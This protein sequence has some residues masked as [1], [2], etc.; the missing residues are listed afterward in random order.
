MAYQCKRC[1]DEGFDFGPKAAQVA[2]SCDAGKRWADQHSPKRAV[3]IQ[4]LANEAQA[5]KDALL[6]PQYKPRS[7]KAG[8][9]AA[10]EVR[11]FWFD[12]T[13]NWKSRDA[14]E[15]TDAR[16]WVRSK[17]G[18]YGVI[19]AQGRPGEALPHIMFDV[20][21]ERTT[22]YFVGPFDPDRPDLDPPEVRRPA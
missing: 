10:G 15:A 13:P 11:R 12:R 19:A 18:Y 16:A 21:G 20:S 14:A 2:C 6:K 1:Y 4:L 3:A 9:N 5:L 17:S 22:L 7:D 8:I